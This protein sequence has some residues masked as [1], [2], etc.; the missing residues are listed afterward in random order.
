MNLRK[1]DHTNIEV[2]EIGIGVWS[3]VTDWWGGEINKAEEILKK[4][5][6]NGINFFDTADVYGEGL[7]EKI[8]AKVF[9][10]KRDKIII[11]TKIGYDFY[12]KSNNRISQRFSIEYIDYAFKKSLERL[13][14]DYI[15][16]LMIH[17][18]KMHIIKNKEILDFLQGLKKE[19]K[20]RLIGVALGPTLGWGEEGIEA[21]KMGYESLEYI[22]N[23]IELKPGIDFLNY[24]IGHFVRVPHASDALIEDKWPIY[25]DP[26]LH[27]SLKDINWI[28]RAVELSKPLLSFA[29]NKGMKLSQLA[30]K[31]ILYNKRVSS[32]LPNISSINELNEFLEVEKLPELTEEEYKY[33]YEY[34]INNFSELNKE[35][36]E[37]TKRYK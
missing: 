32:V 20:V 16:I 21:I 1:I 13:N 27:R 29:R 11:L 8:L 17:N 31:F 25:N 15:D 37:E 4:A 7:G 26:K 22:Y 9:N 35:S 10:T 14:T 36:I 2:S 33:L 12:N 24:D 30:L 3:L 34:S 28:R 5:L 6:E 23:L 18:P 19:G